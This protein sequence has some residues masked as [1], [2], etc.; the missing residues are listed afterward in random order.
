[1]AGD[2]RRYLDL[3][4]IST[5]RLRP[6]HGSRRSCRP[7][8]RRRLRA[9][10]PARRGGGRR[11]PLPTGYRPAGRPSVQ[12]CV[13]PPV[14]FDAAAA[15]APPAASDPVGTIEAQ[16]VAAPPSPASP[17][18]A[19]APPGAQFRAPPEGSPTPETPPPPR[20]AGGLTRARAALGA[21]DRARAALGAGDRAR[22]APGAEARVAPV[23]AP[24]GAGP[25][26]RHRPRAGAADPSGRG[27]SGATGDC[28][29][30]W[31]CSSSPAWPVPPG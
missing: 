21:G 15:G 4:G 24:A 1:M 3:D 9:G 5:R 12:R 19:C 18:S 26:S 28:G 10:R 14:G 31:A 8:G 16:C 27:S 29:S 6:G 22:A 11:C 23:V 30:S 17:L 13:R 25:S 20:P 2:R 7:A